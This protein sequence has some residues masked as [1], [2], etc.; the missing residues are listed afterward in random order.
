MAFSIP[1][2]AMHLNTYLSLVRASALYDLLVTSALA[3]P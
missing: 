3:T 1:E 2:A